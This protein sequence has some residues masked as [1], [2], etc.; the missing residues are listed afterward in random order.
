[1]KKEELDNIINEQSNL[2]N[3]PNNQLV[4]FMELLSE[5]FDITK[6]DLINLSLYLDR[7]EFLYNNILKEYE[8]RAI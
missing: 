5:E 2:V 7:I 4:N 8:K 6:T 3:L 1:M